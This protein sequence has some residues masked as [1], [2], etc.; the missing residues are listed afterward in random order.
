MLPSGTTHIV[1]NGKKTRYIKVWSEPYLVGTSLRPR[2]DFSYWHEGERAW[3]YLGLIP[4]KQYLSNHN[5]KI[6]HAFCF[7]PKRLQDL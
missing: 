5:F 3:G 7:Y 2:Q 6:Q 4:F 1:S